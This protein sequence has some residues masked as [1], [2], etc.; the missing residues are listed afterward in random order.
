V[1]LVEKL[2]AKSLERWERQGRSKIRE[3][4]MDNP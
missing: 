3:R 2:V 4:A 1:Y